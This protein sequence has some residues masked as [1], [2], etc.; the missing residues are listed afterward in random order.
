M[1]RSDYADENVLAMSSV[2]RAMRCSCR[3]IFSESVG[4]C[5][6][7]AEPMASDPDF[8]LRDALLTRL[9]AKEDTLLIQKEY[10]FFEFTGDVR[11]DPFLREAAAGV[12]SAARGGGGVGV[13]ASADPKGGDK[14]KDNEFPSTPP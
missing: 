2:A 1:Q 6:C 11:D 12:L 9:A 7:V 5:R 4:Y 8:E 3:A 10:L 13:D 14:Q